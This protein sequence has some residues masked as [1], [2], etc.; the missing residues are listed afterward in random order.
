MFLFQGCPYRSVPHCTPY[1]TYRIV[2]IFR[3]AKV[4]FVLIEVFHCT[5]YATYHIVGIFCRAKVLF[6]GE[7]LD[8]VSFN[9][10]FPY[11]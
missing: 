9:S 7:R 2:G 8:F 1:A 6:F 11:N 5:L 10:I 4:L 3:R